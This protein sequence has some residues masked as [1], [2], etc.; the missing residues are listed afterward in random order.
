MKKL[1]SLLLLAFVAGACTEDE[2]SPEPQPV[3]EPQPE[4]LTQPAPV[5]TEVTENTLS[6]AWEAVEGAVGYV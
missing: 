3:P 5:Q 2:S 1:L 6:V 4:A